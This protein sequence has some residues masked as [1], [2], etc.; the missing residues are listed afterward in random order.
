MY[1][2][3]SSLRQYTKYNERLFAPLKVILTYV[4]RIGGGE[5]ATCIKR[6]HDLI[7][8]HGKNEAQK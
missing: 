8:Q 6:S 1:N 3:S 7:K 5:W 4:T 2:C